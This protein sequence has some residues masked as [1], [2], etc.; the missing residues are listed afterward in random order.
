MTYLPIRSPVYRASAFLV[1]ETNRRN[2]VPK[3]GIC[4]YEVLTPKELAFNL[5]NATAFWGFHH[6]LL[7]HINAHLFSRCKH[8]H[9]LKS[10][11]FIFSALTHHKPTLLGSAS[12]GVGGKSRP[13]PPLN[14]LNISNS[15]SD[16][17][18]GVRVVDFSL[19]S[20]CSLNPFLIYTNMAATNEEEL[21]LPGRRREVTTEAAKYYYNTVAF[22][23]F[24]HI[25]VMQFS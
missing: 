11:K 15:P 10:R 19:F 12:S 20:V 9:F 4:G 24:K 14:H 7:E 8:P 21:R 23:V 13:L 6:K 16:P 22:V 3:I 1:P 5:S 17:H 25:L 18:R 2:Q